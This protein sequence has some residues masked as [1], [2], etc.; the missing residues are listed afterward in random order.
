MVVFGAVVSSIAGSLTA[1]AFALSFSLSPF[2]LV[3]FYPLGGIMAFSL[4]LYIMYVKQMIE[5]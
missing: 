2:H 1:A 3:V 4:F 5:A